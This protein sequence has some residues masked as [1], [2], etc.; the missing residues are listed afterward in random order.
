MP[1]CWSVSADLEM[2][3]TVGI[4]AGLLMATAHE[5]S[6]TSCWLWS[7]LVKRNTC[8]SGRYARCNNTPAHDSLNAKIAALHGAE[9]AMITGSG[10]AAITTTLLT[11]VKVHAG[12]AATMCNPIIM[13]YDVRTSV[14]AAA[15]CAP[16]PAFGSSI[17]RLITACRQRSHARATPSPITRSRPRC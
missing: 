7:F 14:Y 15:S 3:V 16:Y 10:M 2:E 11:F 6:D 4:L 17:A 1:F 13:M 12:S 9:A 8:M 5:F